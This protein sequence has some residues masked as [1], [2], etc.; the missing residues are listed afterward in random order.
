MRDLGMGKTRPDMSWLRRQ[1]H[2]A[3]GSALDLIMVLIALTNKEINTAERRRPALIVIGLVMFLKP[4]AF[5][6]PRAASGLDQHHQPNEGAFVSSMPHCRVRQGRQI[7]PLT[8]GASY[9]SGPGKAV[10]SA[11]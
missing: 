1:P 11:W 10:A 5:G 8:W 3:W 9:E 6:A 7:Q 2:V 4:C